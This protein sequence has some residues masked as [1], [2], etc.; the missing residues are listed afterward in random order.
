MKEVITKELVMYKEGKCKQLMHKQM[1]QVFAECLQKG[2][3]NS[4]KVQFNSLHSS[5]I[6]RKRVH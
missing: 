4:R 6:E 5:I 2:F 3:D 1:L